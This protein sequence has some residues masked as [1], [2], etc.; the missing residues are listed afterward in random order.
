MVDNE[1]QPPVDGVAEAAPVLPKDCMLVEEVVCKAFVILLLFFF[2]SNSNRHSLKAKFVGKV[3]KNILHMQIGGGK[4]YKIFLFCHMELAKR[5]HFFTGRT[6]RDKSA[7]LRSDN[8]VVTVKLV[9][10]ELL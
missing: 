3:T 7:N 6:M 9:R 5:R 10:Y 2:L 8:G 1:L 4:K